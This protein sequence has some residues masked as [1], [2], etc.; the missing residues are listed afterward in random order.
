M[1][2]DTVKSF[3]SE[4]FKNCINLEN[5]T[6]PSEMTLGSSCFANCR[7]ITELHITN[8]VKVNASLAANGPFAGS[9]LAKVVVEDG[10]TTVPSYIC[11]NCADI[12]DL[13]L[14]DSLNMVGTRCFTGMAGLKE[15]TIKS[16]IV[17]ASASTV[18]PCFEDTGIETITFTDGVTKIGRYLFAGGCADVTEINLPD[19]LE[20][21]AASAFAGCASLTDLEI[22]ESVRTLGGDCFEG[23][24]SL[25][26]L[27]IR[28]DYALPS[29]SIISPFE[30][31]GIET[32][33]FEEGVTV[34]N[35]YFFKDGCRY[36]TELVLPT[37]LTTV[38]GSAFENCKSLK[39]V[40]FRSNVDVPRYGV[41]SP[42]KGGDLE[43]IEFAA[44]VTSVGNYIFSNACSSMTALVLPEGMVSV[45]H[46]TFEGCLSLS[47]LNI[48]S[49]MRE[50]GGEAFAGCAAL[51]TL[52]INAPFKSVAG[53][54]ASPFENG[55]ISVVNV[56]DGLTEINTNYLNNAT[57]SQIRIHIPVSVTKI[58]Y[59]VCREGTDYIVYYD[60]TETQW[61]EVAKDASFAPSQVICS[62]ADSTEAVETLEETTEEEIE[63]EAPDAG[64]DGDDIVVPEDHEIAET[65]GKTEDEDMD[66]DG[67]ADSARDEGIDNTEDEDM[68]DD[69]SA[70]GAEDG[71]TDDDE[72]DDDGLSDDEGDESEEDEPEQDDGP[73]LS[74]ETFR[75]EGE[76]AENE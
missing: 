70:D 40:T 42:F 20:E 66:D 51:T 39:S 55:G 13:Y 75:T 1:L 36:M 38:G 33:V 30:N 26:E 76:L 68:D 5:I 18:V 15:V 52:N 49:T 27:H 64:I 16:D 14:P 43:Q 9:G 3:D 22:P 47:N 25:K 32:L 57:G 34:I 67:T 10:T 2:P 71:G 8:G 41:V 17:R 6:L 4:C 29:G 73:D 45:G 46:H 56:A 44:G 48:P 11:A 61:G 53:A 62:G 54:F 37:T 23:A 50:L 69:A 59:G 72:A 63:E 19:S 31:S 35:S 74:D 12:R 60:G 7:K 58:G 21:I 65:A 28:A 24:A